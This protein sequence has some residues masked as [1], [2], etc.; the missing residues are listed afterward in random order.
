MQPIFKSS[1]FP[2]LLN[3][4]R[5]NTQ[6]VPDL[7]SEEIIFLEIELIYFMLEFPKIIDHLNFEGE[8]IIT[9]LISI[10]SNTT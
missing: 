10:L 1:I 3:F 4:L 9:S 7:L 2:L 8:A 6:T 5:E